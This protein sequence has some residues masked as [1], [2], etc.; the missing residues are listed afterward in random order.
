MNRKLKSTFGLIGLL[1]V[2]VLAGGIYIFVVQQG[3]LTERKEKL[4]ELKAYDYN[5]EQLTLQYEELLLK[6]SSLDSILAARK[7][8]IPQNLSSIKFYN[9]I[10]N[11]SSHYSDLSQIDIEYAEQKPEKE[12]FYFEYKLTG[13][14]T[15]NN[16]YNLIYA[17]EQ[18]KELKKIR[19][20]TL[21]NLVITDNDGYP[22]FLVGFTINVGVYFAN[23]DRFV[24][25]SLV[26]ND[27]STGTMYDAFFPIIRNEIP[28]N[29]DMLLDV[30][31][32]KL[33]ALIPEGAFLADSKGNTYLIWE[34]EPVYLGYLTKIDYEKNKVNFILNKGGIIE[35]VELEI[36][37]ENI[38]EKK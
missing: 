11:V 19:N 34:G 10:N 23:N 13:R 8:N 38:K 22:H 21:S 32:A 25:A 27:L 14:A 36:I 4:E 2:I 37:K 5:T 18:S 9:F 17:I 28:P 7:F 35:R 15:Y 6:A 16:L 33:L 20:V 29:L 26:E 31:G 1:L 12:F 30:Q 24:T 3:K